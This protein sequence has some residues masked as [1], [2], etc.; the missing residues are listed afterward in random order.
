MSKLKKST[1]YCDMDSTL[2]PFE[3]TAVFIK[4]NRKNLAIKNKY[5]RL[6]SW[7]LALFDL[8]KTKMFFSVNNSTFFRDESVTFMKSL[9]CEQFEE[10]EFQQDV[11]N[12]LKDYENIIILTGSPTEIARHIVSRA[13]KELSGKIRDVIGME[14]EKIDG[15]Y[16][17][18]VIDHPYGLRKRQ[19][20]KQNKIIEFDGIGDSVWDIPFLKMCQRKYFLTKN[21]WLAKF[22][23]LFTKDIN[24]ISRKKQYS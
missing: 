12:L 1:I 8:L 22:V 3:S 16:T 15:K 18:K 21:Y 20:L 11:V 23:K 6:N 17:G 10:I 2:I 7:I 9:I 5:K 4:H 13:P 14:L 19:I 24:I